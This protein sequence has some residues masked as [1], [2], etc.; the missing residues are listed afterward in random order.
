MRGGAYTG[1][2]IAEGVCPFKGLHAFDEDSAA[3]F[4][5]R[6]TQSKELLDTVLAHDLVTVVGPSGTGKSS[7]VHAGLLPLL[8]GQRP[9]QPTW[10]A[11]TI[12]P[13]ADP[14]L[15]LADTLSRELDIELSEM[16]RQSEFPAYAE[17]LRQGKALLQMAVKT[18][19][20]KDKGTDR[21]LLVVDQC[22]ELFTSTKDTDRKPFIGMLLDAV[23]QVPLTVVLILRADFFGH[24]IG[25]SPELHERMKPGLFTLGQMQRDELEQAINKPASGDRRCDIQSRSRN[26]SA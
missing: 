9:P 21:L 5:G 25:L 10:N 16:R 14:F 15:E 3:F 12:K 4:C 18:I 11:L 7:L 20:D 17:K 22:E 23:S 6:E 1:A 8:R 2:S 26:Q 19:L 24:A 13:R